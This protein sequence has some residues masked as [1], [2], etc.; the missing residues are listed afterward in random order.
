[1]R[2]KAGSGTKSPRRY[3][4][5]SVAIS[6]LSNPT[7]VCYCDCHRDAHYTV[8][9]HELGHLGMFCYR[10][11]NYTK[12]NLEYGYPWKPN[13]KPLTGFPWTDPLIIHKRML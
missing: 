3:R 7:C 1:M 8:T 13:S 12:Q 5:G 4:Y 6:L 9:D 11:A 2:G 10:C